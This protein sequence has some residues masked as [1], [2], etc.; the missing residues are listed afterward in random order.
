MLPKRRDRE[1]TTAILSADHWTE[2]DEEFKEL[3]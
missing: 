3:K 1:E 2:D